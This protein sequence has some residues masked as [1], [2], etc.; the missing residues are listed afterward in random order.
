V[1]NLRTTVRLET[2]IQGSSDSTHTHPH[3]HIRYTN[4]TGPAI[5]KCLHSPILIEK[6]G[7]NQVCQSENPACIPRVSACVGVNHRSVRTLLILAHKHRRNT[8]FQ[9]PANFHR[10]SGLNGFPYHKWKIFSISTPCNEV[11]REG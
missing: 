1:Y 4:P 7:V 11:R 2:S 10:R 9:E 6:L 8:E 3:A 5:S